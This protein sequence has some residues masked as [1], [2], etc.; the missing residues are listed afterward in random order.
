MY[1]GIGLATARGSG[2]NGYV[3]R[4]LSFVRTN[5][6]SKPE[7]KPD[8]ET[9]K[10]EAYINR[11]GN[12]ELLKHDRKRKIELKCVEM[13]DMMR[14][15][16]YSEEEI[17]Q[18]VEKFRKQLLEKESQREQVEIELAYDVHGRPIGCDTHQ[19]FEANDLKNKKLR[20]AFGLGE[21]DPTVKAKQ[22]EEERRIRAEKEKEARRK[23]Y[24]WVDED[25]LRDDG[26]D[27]DRERVDP[28]KLAHNLAREQKPPSIT[29]YQSKRDAKNKED[30]SSNKDRK[31]DDRKKRKHLTSISNSSSSSSS[32]SSDSS[33]SESDKKK[34]VKSKNL[35]KSESKN[36]K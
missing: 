31:N 11:K 21:F 30:L 26:D 1:N 23:K 14:D 7:Y 15:E 13:E 29:N 16:G 6:D 10:L 33:D 19:N 28:R 27:N 8:E 9:K 34:E 36:S 18:K 2:T 20:E 4:N 35:K 17:Q 12:A 32:N 5:R 24:Q 3:T 25:D 22:E